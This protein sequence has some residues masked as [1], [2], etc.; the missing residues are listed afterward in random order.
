MPL[1][2]VFEIVSELMQHHLF[3]HALFNYTLT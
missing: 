1:P 3:Y 2:Q